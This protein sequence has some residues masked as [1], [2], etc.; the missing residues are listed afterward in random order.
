MADKLVTLT[1]A[2][3][4]RVIHDG[5]VL[6]AGQSFE[7]PPDAAA[8]LLDGGGVEEGTG[9]ATAPTDYADQSV[10]ELEA[11]ATSRGLEVEGTGKDGNVLKS[12]LIDALT[13]DDES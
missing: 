12:D 13:A 10:K 6:D 9:S 11:E 7:V 4:N 1:V 2:E 3:G 5:K 8:T